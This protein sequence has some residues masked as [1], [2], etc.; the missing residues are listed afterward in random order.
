MTTRL[1]PETLDIVWRDFITR[2]ITDAA[3]RRYIPKTYQR[4]NRNYGNSKYF[5]AWLYELGGYV[6]QDHGKRYLEFF[7]DHQSVMFTLRWL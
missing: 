7:N 5:E 4:E 3:K 2:R 6:V 1:P